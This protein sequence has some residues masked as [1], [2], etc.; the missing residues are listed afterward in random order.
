[1]S[2]L[3][4]LLLLLAAILLAACQSLPQKSA[5]DNGESSAAETAAVATAEP[6]QTPSA[7]TPSTQSAKAD[8]KPAAVSRKPVARDDSGP[9]LV[10]LRKPGV[11]YQHSDGI[12]M[13]YN[14]RLGVYDVINMP[15]MYFHNQLYLH[16]A[17]QV[18]VV[19]SQFDGPWLAAKPA[20]IPKSLAKAKPGRQL[21]AR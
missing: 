16:F 5:L 18:W 19:A 13:R 21:S 7:A 2:P 15:N 3:K 11:I 6:A 12:E 17:N 14:A 9:S 8:S 20:Q 1:M 4:S 10:E